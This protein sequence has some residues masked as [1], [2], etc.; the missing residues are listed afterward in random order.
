MP[1]SN[2]KLHSISIERLKNIQSLQEV[3]L[4]DGPLV[5]ITGAN[6]AG[7][8]TILHALAC[9]F[10][11]PL[12]DPRTNYRF[13]DFFLPTSDSRWQ[14]SEFS[15]CHSF[16]DGANSFSRAIQQYGKAEDR[17][18]PR[19]ENRPERRLDYIGVRSCV[20]RIE[21]EK[22]ITFLDLQT[23][24]ENTDAARQIREAASRVL[25]KGYTE[26]ATKR[27]G[28]GR[29]YRGVVAGG[30]T[31]SSLSMGAGEQRVF[32][33]LEKLYLLP[34]SSLLLVDEIDLLLHEDAFRRLIDEVHARASD[35]DLQVIFTT[36]RE[37]ILSK[38]DKVAV[39]H[40]FNAGQNTL[41]LPGT[42]PD[43]WHRLTGIARRDL[44]VFVEDDLSG[45][46]V[47]KVAEALHLRRH[48]AISAVG[49]AGNVVTVACGFALREALTDNQA[50]FTDGDVLRT[51]EERLG[52]INRV[53]TGNDQLAIARRALVGPRI[54]QFVLPEQYFPER[55]IH[56]M[57]VDEGLDV[58]ASDIEIVEIARE[59]AMPADRHGYVNEIVK[60]L[61]H[62]REVGL[63]KVVAAAS[64]SPLWPAFVQPV[65]AWLEGKRTDLCL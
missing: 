46:I 58:A 31:Y 33:L 53:L 47:A 4:D 24:V 30:V 6:G 29:T 38:G 19:Y 21:E 9:S 20:P 32:S 13:P 39:V 37:S 1:K 15:I 28:T 59:I 8:S 42:H 23:A 41:A 12:G 27:H 48:V 34:R 51:E 2:Q 56:E 10:K 36:H 5:A 22:S 57:L 25:N 63:A 62:S 60:R 45:A 52:Q 54:G 50:F 7:K 11:P 35:R 16:R 17:W 49:A 14:G 61:G 44:E 18:T 3:K 65:S 55:L 40:L 64:A 26:L 43:V